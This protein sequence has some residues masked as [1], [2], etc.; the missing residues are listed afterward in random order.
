M[1]FISDGT[2]TFRTTCPHVQQLF[3]AG[4]FNGWSATATPMTKI[5][6]H[7]WQVAL[8]LEPG[9]YRFRYVTDDGRWLTDFS[10]FGVEPNKI[11]GW[12]SVVLVPEPQTAESAEYVPTLAVT[13]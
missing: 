1:T 10:A 5:D 2:C 9:T 4:D 6:D 12:D 8:D 3:L 7:T 13:A 11:D